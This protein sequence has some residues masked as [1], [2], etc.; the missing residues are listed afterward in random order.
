MHVSYKPYCTPYVDCPWDR[1]SNV[2]MWLMVNWVQRASMILHETC[3]KYTSQ[4]YECSTSTSFP[5]EACKAMTWVSYHSLTYH[6]SF[7]PLHA[8]HSYS[9]TACAAAWVSWESRHQ[10]P[11]FWSTSG[12]P[13]CACEDTVRQVSSFHESSGMKCFVVSCCRICRKRCTALSP[14]LRIKR[15]E[16]K[17]CCK[18]RIWVGKTCSPWSMK[19]WKWHQAASHRF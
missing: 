19:Q 9:M 5:Y 7:L 3:I 13:T 2:F 4:K 14:S 15:S 18:V 6:P 10:H 12:P 17:K 1:F 11:W 16:S 8:A